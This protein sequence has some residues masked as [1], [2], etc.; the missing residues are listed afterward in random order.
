MSKLFINGKFLAQRTTGVQRFARG[1][2]V[3]L[4]KLLSAQPFIDEVVI[5]LPGSA[6]PIDG[7][8]VITQKVVGAEVRSLTVW[9]QLVLPFAARSGGLL[10]LSG[11]AP[12]F[13]KKVLSTIHDA[14]IFHFPS[15]YSWRFVLWYKFLF[16]LN[17]LRFGRFITVSNSSKFDLERVF[18]KSVFFVVPNSAEHIVADLADLSILSRLG[19]EKGKFILSVGSSNPTKNFSLLLE[20]FGGVSCVSNLPLTIV[21]SSN[22]NVF[23]S[24]PI[25]KNFDNILF[26]GHL[27]DSEL[28]ALY[29]NALCFV[30]PSLYE[31]FGIPP[32]EAMLCSCPVLAS[33]IPVLHEVC[34][35]AAIF[36]DPTDVGDL[37]SCLE[38]VIVD[39]QLRNMLIH[40][41]HSRASIFSWL[42]AAESLRSAL[43][44][45]SFVEIVVEDVR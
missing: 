35:D 34:G 20:Y 27:T 11:S 38:K 23:N 25:S 43:I 39:E 10:C 16:Y 3:A 15:A 32:L 18:P 12:I 5:L 45:T 33:D 28:R 22:S 14:A 30:F 36:F 40:K 1:V 17:M 41:G 21:G 7:L 19:L 44:E 8:S 37:G 6:T 24:K 29:E 9:E 26:T 2:I 4:D 31:G 42:S 13:G